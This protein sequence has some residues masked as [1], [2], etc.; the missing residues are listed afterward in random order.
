MGICCHHFYHC[1]IA[2]A[3]GDN[4]DSHY[5]SKLRPHL[6]RC[7]LVTLFGR[8]TIDVSKLWQDDWKSHYIG[9]GPLLYPNWGQ[10]CQDA[11]FS[12]NWGKIQQNT[13]ITGMMIRMVRKLSF[14]KRCFHWPEDFKAAV[15]IGLDLLGLALVLVSLVTILT[16][17]SSSILCNLASLSC[18]FKSSVCI[19]F[20]LCLPFT[21]LCVNRSLIDLWAAS[22]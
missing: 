2:I 14:G 16:F 5:I 9:G 11:W 10:I 17:R 7:L 15:T 8:R 20:F 22:I 1:Y 21:S 12:H 4:W 3:N 6:P 13:E 18:N 19:A